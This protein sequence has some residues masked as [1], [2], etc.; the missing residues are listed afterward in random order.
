MLRATSQSRGVCEAIAAEGFPIV[1]IGERF[2]GNAIPYIFTESREASR[3]AVNYLLELGHKR[4]AICLNVVEDA[5]HA[6][7]LAGY[8]DAFTARGMT[9]DESLI[10]R[11]PANRGRGAAGSSSG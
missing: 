10:W 8:R 5:D 7:R 4:V 6:D 9:A 1:V 2:T 11:I 3:D